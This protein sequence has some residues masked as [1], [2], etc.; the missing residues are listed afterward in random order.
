M[1]EVRWLWGFVLFF[2]PSIKKK[3]TIQLR[4]VWFS[5]SNSQ[6]RFDKKKKRET[7]SKLGCRYLYLLNECV[8]F[9]GCFVCFLLQVLLCFVHILLHLLPIHLHVA[10]MIG[11]LWGGR[12]IWKY[13]MMLYFVL[14]LFWS[15]LST[16]QS[17]SVLYCITVWFMVCIIETLFAK[18]NPFKQYKK[19]F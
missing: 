18:Q 19:T 7:K 10:T 17:F 1:S 5:F 14:H 11:N 4:N 2:P 16:K 6:L 3:Y 12:I 13:L 9:R 8:Y 15:Q